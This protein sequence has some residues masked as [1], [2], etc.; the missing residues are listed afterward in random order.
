MRN[1]LK[2]KLF[3]LLC[4]IVVSVTSCQRGHSDIPE[5]VSIHVTVSQNAW[6]YSNLSNNNYFYA[7]VD[8]PEITEAVFDGGV[9]K[10]YRTFNYDTTDATQIEMPYVRHSEYNVSGDEW[11]FY[12]ETV[13]YDYGIGDIYIYYRVSDFDY[14]LDQSFVPETMNF[15]CV[16]RSN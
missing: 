12:T 8:M 4:A 16:I 13:D 2:S 5:I 1:N 14:E 9:I 10:M 3:I 15:R 11:A 7:V 6:Q